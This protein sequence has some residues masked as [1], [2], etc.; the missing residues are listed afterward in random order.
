M[1]I[2]RPTGIRSS[3]ITAKSVYVNR[4]AFLRAA[5]ASLGVVVAQCGGGSP[6]Q[7][8]PAAATPPGAPPPLLQPEAGAA[9]AASPVPQRLERLQRRGLQDTTLRKASIAGTIQQF[10]PTWLAR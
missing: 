6:P 1:L 4:R 3:E 8:P 2:K 10:E 7:A 9:P 5:T